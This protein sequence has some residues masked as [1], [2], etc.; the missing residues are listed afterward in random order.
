MNAERVSM[1]E[2]LRE[3]EREMD[4]R[5]DSDK[6]IEV[7]SAKNVEL[8][9]ELKRLL[10]LREHWERME[11]VQQQMDAE[12]ERYILEL[13][14]CLAAKEREVD[15][16]SKHKDSLARQ[17]KHAQTTVLSFKAHVRSLEDTK[18]RMAASAKRLSAD[19]K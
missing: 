19:G 12:N 14:E 1:Q 7:L 6:M 4:L 3:F 18:R 15:T 9:F 11:R 5:A 16:V 10:E 17:L 13:N 8:E 2:A